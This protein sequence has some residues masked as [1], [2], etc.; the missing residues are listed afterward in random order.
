MLNECHCNGFMFN[1]YVNVR[2]CQIV[3]MEYIILNFL[4]NEQWHLIPHMQSAYALTVISKATSKEESRGKLPA[5]FQQSDV[6]LDLAK[7]LEIMRLKFRVFWSHWYF[8][9]GSTAIPPMSQHICIALIIWNIPGAI[10]ILWIISSHPLLVMWLL[11]HAGIKWSHV[12]KMELHPDQY[13]LIQSVTAWQ[14][15]IYKN[16]GGT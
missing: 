12:K 2:A 8:T 5:F 11:I 14:E 4:S 3:S 9:G 7:R 16:S 1:S 10:L 13:M 15:Y 6:I